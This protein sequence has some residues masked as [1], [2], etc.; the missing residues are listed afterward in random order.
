MSKVMQKIVLFIEPNDDAWITPLK[1][2]NLFMNRFAVDEDAASEIL[3]IFEL[4]KETINDPK[5]T[6]FVT[7]TN[8]KGKDLDNTINRLN[9]LTII[10]RNEIYIDENFAIL[11]IK[12]STA[13]PMLEKPA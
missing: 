13:A 8:K 11:A 7:E 2:G 5:Y 1:I 4:E 6:N 10:N 12:K 9:C 3:K